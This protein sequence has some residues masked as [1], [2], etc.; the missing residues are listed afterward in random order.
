MILVE[1]AGLAARLQVQSLF[2]S[3]QMPAGDWLRP[4]RAHWACHALNRTATTANLESKSSYEM[5]FGKVPEIPAPF[6]KPGYVKRKHANKLEPK[7]EQSIY[8]G[9][10]P[11]RS[12]DFT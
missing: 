9:L 12:R 7:A 3:I 8:I 6:L 1:P 2:P 11:Y 4:S 5:R 10:S